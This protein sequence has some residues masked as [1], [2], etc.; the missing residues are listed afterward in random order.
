MIVSMK[1]TTVIDVDENISLFLR[2]GVSTARKFE[3]MRLK[4]EKKAEHNGKRTKWTFTRNGK[5]TEKGDSVKS[6]SFGRWCHLMM[7]ESR[8]KFCCCCLIRYVLRPFLKLVLQNHFWKV[9]FWFIPV[10][11][12]SNTEKQST[13]G[14]KLMGIWKTGC[15]EENVILEWHFTLVDSD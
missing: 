11:F 12:Y 10:W 9:S 7:F 1:I 8:L 5:N 6:G 3:V 14:T 15:F 4:S 13:K 2:N